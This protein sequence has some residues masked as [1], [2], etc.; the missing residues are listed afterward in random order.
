MAAK[1]VPVIRK[2]AKYLREVLSSNFLHKLFHITR[3]HFM[4]RT[5]SACVIEYGHS[6]KASGAESSGYFS[7]SGMNQD[8]RLIHRPMD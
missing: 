3:I 6:D 4:L 5:A 8:Y 1:V 2:L 7:M